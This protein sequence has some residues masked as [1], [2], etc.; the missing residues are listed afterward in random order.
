[1]VSGSKDKTVRVWDSTL[2]RCV[3]SSTTHSAAVTKVIWTPRD[4]IISCS[5]DRTIVVWSSKLS[6]IRKLGQHSHWVNCMSLSTEYL[7]RNS[8]F[9]FKEMNNVSVVEALSKENKVNKMKKYFDDFYSQSGAEYLV[10]GSDDNTINLFCLGKLKTSKAVESN[11]DALVNKGL[12]KR[13]FEE[14]NLKEVQVFEK[15]SF[16]NSLEKQR[17]I[18]ENFCLIRRYTGHSKA[19]NHVQFAPNGFLF[20]SAS[21]DKSLRVWNVLQNGCLAVLRGHVAAVYR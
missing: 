5:E 19:I 16:S 4:F 15:F 1:L 21:F 3:A 7:I 6:Y 9:E 18:S 8:Y 20:I 17:K 11:S 14:S 2:K 13:N 10:T 12:S